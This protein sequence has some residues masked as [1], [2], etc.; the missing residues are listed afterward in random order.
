MVAEVG[1]ACS[2]SGSRRPRRGG[3]RSSRNGHS[4]L[5]R[6]ANC[7]ISHFILSFTS[8]KASRVAKYLARLGAFAA[9]VLGTLALY[10]SSAQACSLSSHCYLQA[11]MPPNG[12]D[13]QSATSY[14]TVYK[15][16]ADS[17]KFGTS[18][19]WVCTTDCSRTADWIETGWYKGDRYNGST[20]T[21][22]VWFAAS[23]WVDYSDCNWPGGYS[24]YYYPSRPI[25][26]GQTHIARITYYQSW[27]WRAFMD[28]NAIMTS[29][30]CF[31]DYSS[32]LTTGAEITS[33]NP[34]LDGNSNK[35]Q[36]TTRSG[37][38]SYGW[39]GSNLQ[40]YGLSNPPFGIQWID[41]YDWVHWWGNL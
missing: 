38:S 15:M 28:G 16:T 22:E 25:A 41:Q 24:A 31:D 3:G 13:Y 11:N 40:R 29:L 6:G 5:E 27:R 7:D 14:I 2:L 32:N 21:S 35:L 20:D 18:E 1:R 8:R 26:Y 19:M 36:K 37:V 12:S 33:S 10:P 9:L 34:A 30:P 39:P 17:G 23:S 4:S